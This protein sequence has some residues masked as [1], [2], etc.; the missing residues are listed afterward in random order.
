MNRIAEP[1]DRQVKVRWWAVMLKRRH[2]LFRHLWA[3]ELHVLCQS[4]RQC[5][6]IATSEHLRVVLRGERQQRR[7]RGREILLSL[8]FP[9]LYYMRK[10][11]SCDR[12]NS[13][14][15]CWGTLDAVVVNN[16]IIEIASLYITLEGAC[17]GPGPDLLRQ[18]I[19]WYPWV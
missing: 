19:P 1:K 2:P 9:L 4:P 18:M 7:G 15:L 17:S 11:S 13:R 12:I 16:Y 14:S 6:S 5:V 3:W 8:D 10:P